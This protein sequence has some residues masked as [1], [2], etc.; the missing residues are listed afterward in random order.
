MMCQPCQQIGVPSGLKELELP[1]G[2]RS[3]GTSTQHSGTWMLGEP[4]GAGTSGSVMEATTAFSRAAA[5][6]PSYTS[7]SA[8]GWFST[9]V[10]SVIW[11]TVPQGEAVRAAGPSHAYASTNMLSHK[12]RVQQ[13]VQYSGHAAA[14]DRA[15][16]YKAHEVQTATRAAY[17]RLVIDN[18]N[19]TCLRS[20]GNTGAWWAAAC[21]ALGGDGGVARQQEGDLAAD[22]ADAEAAGQHA[23]HEDVVQ[24]GA[25]LAQHDR[26]LRSRSKV[27]LRFASHG[28]PGARV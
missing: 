25:R 9:V 24:R 27:L 20:I 19:M 10:H 12:D 28:K 2:C 23:Q 4:K 15:G 3:G 17:H 22:L 16:A 26:R 18:H 5:L 1:C 6:S 13:L 21:L 14:D 8:T 7:I 11:G